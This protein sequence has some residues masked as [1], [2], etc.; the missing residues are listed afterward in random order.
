M[1]DHLVVTA[2]A[3]PDPEVVA[4]LAAAGVAT[5]HE[6]AGRI[7]LLDPGIR[8]VQSGA[9]VAGPAVTVLCAAGDNIMIHAAVEVVRPGDVVVVATT[10]PSTDGMVGELLATSFMA[11]GCRA[12]VIDAGVR[13]VA[14]LREMGFAV[15]SRAVHAQGT[16]KGTAGSVNLPLTIGGMTVAP[17]DVVVADDDGVMILPRERADRVLALA[18]ERLAREEAKR[19]RLQAGE[20]SLDL[21]G[22]RE[23]LLGM[24]VRW[25]E[26]KDG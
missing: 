13:D 11:R 5:V 2:I 24:G 19:A 26:E 1:T 8:P 14:D 21:D 22:L 12:L 17:G 25:V 18:R 20:T 16:V 4:G 6:A 15:W 3:R 10:T 7:G 9:R 23:R